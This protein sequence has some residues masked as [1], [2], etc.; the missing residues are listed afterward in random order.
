M[1]T[2]PMSASDAFA[3]ET[4]QTALKAALAALATAY[5]AAADVRVES[6]V[7]DLT[8]TLDEANADL[9]VIAGQIEDDA[10]DERAR[11]ARAWFSPYAA[12]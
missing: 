6:L 5:K 3:I 11:A 1:E 9:N 10:A 7:A 4:A 12:A 2:T 8:N